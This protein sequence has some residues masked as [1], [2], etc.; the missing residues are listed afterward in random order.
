M[1]ETEKSQTFFHQIIPAA[2]SEE[3]RSRK[4][5]IIPGK[6]TIHTHTTLCIDRL[7][8]VNNKNIPIKVNVR[9]VKYPKHAQFYLII[10]HFVEV[11]IL[12]HYSILIRVK[13][14]RMSTNLQR[15]Y[16][17]WVCRAGFRIIV[18]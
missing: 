1:R 8:N 10:M 5:T 12:P 14:R 9:G 4:S 17:G 16:I 13:E 7:L 18:A 15:L 11:S 3:F 6:L 2:Q